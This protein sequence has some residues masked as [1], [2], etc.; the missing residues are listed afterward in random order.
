MLFCCVII[1]SVLADLRFKV[2]RNAQAVFDLLTHPSSK[3]L[4]N[5]WKSL[6]TKKKRKQQNLCQYLST[7]N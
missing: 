7:T 2:F 3:K 5:F 1:Y 4:K 6:G